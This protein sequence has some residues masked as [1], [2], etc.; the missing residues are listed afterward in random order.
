M[1][2]IPLSEGSFTVS[3]SK[4]FVPFVVNK[5]EIT[6]R[7][8]GSLLVEIQP[9]VV[10]TSSDI[11]LLDT[12]LGLSDEEGQFQLYKNLRNNGLN[13]DDITKVVMSHL[14][15]DHAGGLLN[16]FTQQSAFENATYYIQKQEL[17][18]ALQSNSTSYDKEI[19]DMLQSDKRIVLQEANKGFIAQGIT[20]E[21]TSAHSQFHRVIWITEERDTVFFGADDAPQLIH[22]QTRIAAKYD[23]DGKKAMQLRQQWMQEGT[24]WQFLFYH[25]LK[26]PIKRF[27]HK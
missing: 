24:S 26:T 11:I 13:A 20:Y 4:K 2:V 14:H 12:G 6:A 18:G 5:D 9:F 17:D 8:Q 27:A 3:A 10:I 23:F 22:M 15:K 16:P 1:K 25:D 7:S 21:V 19:L